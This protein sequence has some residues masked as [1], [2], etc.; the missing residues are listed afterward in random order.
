MKSKGLLARRTIIT[1]A[2][3]EVVAA[4]AVTPLI[5]AIKCLNLPESR[6]KLILT[7]KCLYE[8]VGL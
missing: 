2:P 4:V 8:L 6:P 7:W 5:Q 3:L 1:A